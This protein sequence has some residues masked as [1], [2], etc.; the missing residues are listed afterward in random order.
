MMGIRVSD[1]A[2]ELGMTNADLM[3]ALNDLGVAVPGPAA[4]VE[5]EAAQVM[6]E[7]FGA[8]GVA[9]KVAEVP[10]GATVKD[11]AIAMGVPAADVQKRLMAMG[12]L[13][14]VNQ[15]LTADTAKALASVYG[16]TL[17]SKIEPRAQA[18]QAAP[19]ASAKHR[20][21]ATGPQARPPVVTIMGH[22][23]HGKTTLLDAIRHT[24]VVAGEFGGITQHIGAYQVEVDFEGARRKVTFIDTPGHAAFT[25]MRA[26]G[27]SVTDIA[28]LVVAADDGIMPQSIEAMDHARAAEVPIIV[29]VNKIDRPD[30]NPD[31]V[32]TQLAEHGLVPRE[33]GGDVECVPVS[34]K[35]GTG[36]DDLLQ[37][38]LL[39][40]D[41]MDLRADPHD[42]PKGVIVEA[43]Q[44]VGRG[45]VAT[46]LVQQGTLRPGDCVV[47]G[48][49]HGRIRA[50]MSER[51]ERLNKAGPATPV[52]ILGL[53][54]VPAAGERLEVVKDERTARQTAERRADQLRLA[55][56]STAQ[57]VTLEEM[58]RRIREGESRDLNLVV[59]ADVQGSVEAVVGQL[60]QVSQDEVRL[61]V[62]SSGV[63]NINEND[64]MLASATGGIVVGFNVRAEQP[65]Q[66]AAER[67][68]VDIRTYNVIYELT[69]AVEKAMRGLLAPVFEERV[70]GKAVCRQVFRTPR[71]V[72]IAGSYVTDGKVTRNAEARV[73]RGGALIYTG[74]VESLRHVKDDVRE[75]A[76][77]FECGIV[78]ADFSTIQVDDV[79]EAFEMQ[80][81]ER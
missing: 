42:K 4:I 40:A 50:M 66:A 75:M 18:P 10:V 22:V 3:A 2:K 8:Q 17:R 56:V 59:K 35:H 69:E 24:D 46:A 71:G 67:E 47:C 78:L 81:V 76:Q 72:V 54:I 36:L 15:R 32:K 58:A 16:F 5:S 53:S 48:I 44:E 73:Y 45:P 52:E 39:Q 31:R 9:G 62:V 33:Y 13:A 26:R 74:K 64:I 63:G 57:R 80:Q 25:A 19:K 34:A 30:A 51:G 49:A 68:H 1:L 12:V 38:I 41:M 43:K 23:D 37:T 65:A 20:G 77:G 55:R 70:L 7:M 28:V 60:Y 61:H 79:I 11:L 27:A 29:A 21:P 14:A 6:R